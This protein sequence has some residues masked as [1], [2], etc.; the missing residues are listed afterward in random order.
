MSSIS[1]LF[2]SEERLI[3]G[4]MSGTSA[5]GVDAAIVRLRGSGRSIHVETLGFEHVAYDAALRE[6]LLRNAEAATSSVREIALLDAL[7]A[8][9]FADAVHAACQI[10]GIAV[11]DL[12]AIGSHGHTLH[13][14]P[15]PQPFAG[16]WVP[17][18]LQ[19]GDG[20]TLA[21]LTGV[22]VVGRFRSADVALGG[23]GAPLVPY[24][25]WALASHP[26]ETRLLLNLGGIANITVLPAGGAATDVRAF[27]TGPA[28]MVIDALAR[29]LT[30]Q[31]FDHN[32]EAALRGTPDEAILENLLAEPYFHREPPKSTG[33]ELFGVDYVE[34][35]VASGLSPDD[36]LATATRLTV[37]SV[38]HAIDTLVKPHHRPDVLLVSGG[39]V[40]NKALMT[41]L[42][43]AVHPVEVRPSESIG[44][45]PDAKEAICFAV[46][47]HEFFNGVPTNLP[48]VTGASR[49]VVLGELA[50]G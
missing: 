18:T 13:H 17:A 31:A 3:A 34:A 26:V 7:L 8:R 22:P 28:N 43:E 1:D 25:D 20:A 41:W 4:L 11:D 24:V 37:R 10:A 29:R 15:D 47:A 2:S 5:D 23:Q 12:T 39:G 27:D 6:A 21:A 16:H 48:G 49:A 40:H 14:L 9:R 45:A 19:I 46:L 36:L 50:P 30:D 38:V 33:R 35:L 42:E 44:L 32:G